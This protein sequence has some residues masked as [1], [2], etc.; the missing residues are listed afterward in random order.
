MEGGS[1]AA[2]DEVALNNDRI[3]RV[4]VVMLRAV[5]ESL[6]SLGWRI[7]SVTLEVPEEDPLPCW[8]LLRGRRVFEVRLVPYDD[9]RIQVQGEWIAPTPAPSLIDRMMRR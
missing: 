7:R 3:N 1:G 9:G 6:L 8:V 2:V 4:I 5:I